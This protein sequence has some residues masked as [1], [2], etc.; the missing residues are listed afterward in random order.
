MLGLSAIFCELGPLQ[1]GKYVLNQLDLG[2]MSVEHKLKVW[3]T[4]LRASQFAVLFCAVRRL[5]RCL[6]TV[7][8]RQTEVSQLVATSRPKEVR[9]ASLKRRRL[10]L[11]V[12]LRFG[13]A[14]GLNLNTQVRSLAA[15]SG[16]SCHSLRNLFDDGLAGQ[17]RRHLVVV[18]RLKPW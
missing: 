8:A 6:S 4:P 17:A 15:R 18:G 10:R 3:T 5:L 11:V 13:C 16:S 9:A 12:S 7:V 1:I 14:A 2:L